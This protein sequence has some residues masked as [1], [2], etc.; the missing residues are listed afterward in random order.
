M[1]TRYRMFSGRYCFKSMKLTMAVIEIELR[2]PSMLHGKKGFERLVYAAKNV[3]NQSLTWLFCDLSP[4]KD[5]GGSSPLAQHHP[6]I[7]RGDPQYGVFEHVLCPP[8]SQSFANFTYP[9][10]SDIFDTDATYEI[11]EWLG[12]VLLQSPRVLHGDNIDPY[13]SRYAAPEGSSE[14]QSLRIVKW[15]GLIG[16][17]WLTR[18]L[19]TC[20]LVF[21][22]SLSPVSRRKLGDTN[23]VLHS[24]TPFVVALTQ[25]KYTTD[26]NHAFITLSNGLRFLPRRTVQRRLASLMGT[27]SFCCLKYRRSQDKTL[28]WTQSIE[29]PVWGHNR[30]GR[31]KVVARSISEVYSNAYASN[32]STPSSAAK[33]SEMNPQRLGNYWII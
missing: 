6:A 13:L 7:V 18:I 1:K 30:R 25:S 29:V 8:F 9:A 16:A 22:G 28:P 14:L 32:I 3:L 4:E 21:P 24:N 19:N 17:R 20:M 11:V 27:R 2:K 33:L 23:D 31:W 5:Q 10:A 12:L 26:T 15:Q